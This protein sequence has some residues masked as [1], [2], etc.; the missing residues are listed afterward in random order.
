M[1]RSFLLQIC[2]KRA[3]KKHFFLNFMTFKPLQA[4][5]K[6]NI[7]IINVK[8]KYYYRKDIETQKSQKGKKPWS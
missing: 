6:H 8:T 2:P 3:E 7:P 1:S 5:M 4:K